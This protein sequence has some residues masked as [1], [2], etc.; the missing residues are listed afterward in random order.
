MKYKITPDG[1]ITPEKELVVPTKVDVSSKTETITPLTK[2]V[3]E[4]SKLLPVKDESVSPHDQLQHISKFLKKVKQTNDE[5]FY[6]M[7]AS[8]E[9]VYAFIT[10]IQLVRLWLEFRDYIDE[11]YGERCVY[12]EWGYDFEK[13]YIRAID[14]HAYDKDHKRVEVDPKDVLLEIKWINMINIELAYAYDVYRWERANMNM[15]FPR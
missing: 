13:E 11:V 7:V 10:K 15:G 5:S 8:D 12:L 4:L 6:E 9:D 2:S 14:I 3:E 1:D